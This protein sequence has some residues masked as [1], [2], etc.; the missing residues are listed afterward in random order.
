MLELPDGRVAA[1]N[2]AI[3]AEAA[4]RIAVTR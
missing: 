3:V 2:A 4:R 1:D